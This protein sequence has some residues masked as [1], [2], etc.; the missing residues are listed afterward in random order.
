M[1][2]EVK[3]K[4]SLEGCNNKKKQLLEK[5]VQ[6]YKEVFQELQEM[7]RRE[8]LNII[9]NRYQN[10]YYLTLGFKQNLSQ[11]QMK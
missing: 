11:K 8:K 9:F 4:E 3:I 2:K 5:Q 7:Q 10:I 1:K 6:S